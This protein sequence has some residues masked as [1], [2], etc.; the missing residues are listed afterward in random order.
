[1][2]VTRAKRTIEIDIGIESTYTHSQQIVQYRCGLTTFSAV[3]FDERIGHVRNDIRNDSVIHLLL[4]LLDRRAKQQQQLKN[5]KICFCF[6]FEKI[7]CA[8]KN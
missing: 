8:R 6:A 1:M 7:C 4:L 5:R 2:S 3:L